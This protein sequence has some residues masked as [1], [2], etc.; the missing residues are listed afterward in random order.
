MQLVVP[1]PVNELLPQL[2]PV[3]V[4]IIC[5]ADPLSL[6]EK[7]FEVL[8]CVAVS[9]TVSELVTAAA[10]AVK[11]ALLAPEGTVTEAGTMMA[12]LLLARLTGNPVLGAAALM[13]TV[14]LSVPAPIIEELV[15]VRPDSDA[16]VEPLPCSFTELVAAWAVELVIAVTLSSPV[17]SVVEPGSKRT[18]ATRLPPALRVA[19][20]V[21]ACTVKELL[22][23][24]S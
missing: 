24:L 23:L 8:P 22:E 14:Q 6:I 7:V 16:V 17:V 1:A 12:L 18:C 21:P 19:G 4:V 13:L 20:S 2:K 3:T 11:L 15:H 10:L 5:D 9:V